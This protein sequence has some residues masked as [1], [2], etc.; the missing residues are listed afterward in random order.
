[1]LS[2]DLGEAT[3]RKQ[4]LAICQRLLLPLAPDEDPCVAVRTR[5]PKH[6]TVLYCCS[7]CRRVVNS[8]QDGS[9]KDHP[10]NELGLAA[11]MLPRATTGA[12]PHALRQALVGRAAHGSGARGGRRAA[13]TRA[14]DP[15][16]EPAAAAG[17]AA[18]DDR[19]HHVHGG[20][21]R[22]PSARNERRQR[23]AA[24]L[25]VRGGQV[26][27]RPQVVLRAE[28]A[29][30]ELRRRA[31]RVRARSWSRHPHLWWLVRLV[32]HVR[33]ARARHARLALPRRDLLPALR[34][35]DACRQGGRRGDAQRA[36]QAALARVPLLPQGRSRRTARA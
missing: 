21:K 1:M 20:A 15:V 36:P 35:C 32:Q 11:S 17:P 8:V 2:Y 9:G 16:D 3:R 25:V 30:H 6:A 12:R 28:P 14:L 31:P 27:A 26:P 10:F 33:H 5:L 4:A 19:G 23:G 34:L 13:R 24:R 22:K 7:E 18:R 29:G